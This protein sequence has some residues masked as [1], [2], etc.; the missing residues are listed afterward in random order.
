MQLQLILSKGTAGPFSMLTHCLWCLVL[1]LVIVL[2]A[3]CGPSLFSNSQLLVL[4]LSMMTGLG[5]RL[6]ARA[7]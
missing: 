1:H 4:V 5:I 7:G 3:E 2:N 6:F